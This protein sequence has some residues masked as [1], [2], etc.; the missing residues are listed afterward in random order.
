[1]RN[2]MKKQEECTFLKCYIPCE[3]GT[4]LLEITKETGYGEIYIAFYSYGHSNQTGWGNRLKMIWK[5]LR[6]GSPY[7]DNIILNTEETNKLLD[8]LQKKPQ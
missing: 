6:T 1:M 3:C 2:I 7:S 4:E 8:F 5:V